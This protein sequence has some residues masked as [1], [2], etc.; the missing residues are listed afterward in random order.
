MKREEPGM[1]AGCDEGGR[2]GDETGTFEASR[3]A[4]MFHP[5]AAILRGPFCS[6]DSMK[7]NVVLL[8]LFLTC[9]GASRVRAQFPN[10]PAADLVLGAPDFVTAGSAA[11]T[12]SGVS[13]P[14][15][16]AI[17]PVSGKVFV[18]AKPQNRVLR[19]ASV[20]A[21]SNGAN[22][23]AVLGQVNFSSLVFA[24]TQSN[25]S[26]PAGVFVDAKGRLWVSDSGNNRVLMFE[27]AAT[28]SNG[29]PA[30]RVLGQLNFTS[31]TSATSNTRM[32]AP[33]SLV[34]DSN[35]N[36]WVADQSNHRVLKFASVSSLANGAAASVVLG[37]PDFNTGTS[38]LTASKMNAVTGVA[39]D[40]AGRLWVADQNN[41]RILRFDNAASLVTG[42]SASGV[43]GQTDFVT[44]TSGANELKMNNPG[45][46][47]V[48]ADGTVFALDFGNHRIV[49]YRGAA[50][51]A[52]GAAMDA[53]FGQPDF[54]SN[55]FG[56]SA[57]QIRFPQIGI[58]LDSAGGLWISDTGNNRVLRFSPDRTAPLL[59]ITTRVPRKTG[60]ARLA[61]S[62]TASDEGG[63]AS[64][65]FRPGRGAFKAATGTTTWRATVSLKPGKNVL[66][67]KAVDAVGNLSA[68]RRVTVT[69]E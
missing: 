36:L 57:R 64:V 21:L 45:A 10:F 54:T 69:R 31:G 1:P 33:A 35:D 15:G 16:I 34:V 38:G 52:N 56:L 58:T 14:R 55:A 30:D 23:E 67:F 43:L 46:L 42:A 3:I 63:I 19:F 53:V 20:A 13:D 28:L 6:F 25:L 12:P 32:A 48:D 61:V 18:V 22:A 66:D 59:T 11:S 50:S 41:N 5:E 9:F 65:Q 24:T 62:G 49:I 4:L 29:A 26:S 47:A 17:D 51:K 68:T 8:V 60:K 27:G 2:E 37:Q 39:V 7:A 40:T 44:A